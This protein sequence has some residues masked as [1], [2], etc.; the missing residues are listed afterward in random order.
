MGSE[1]QWPNP[2]VGP[3]GDCVA[4]R[5]FEVIAHLLPPRRANLATKPEPMESATLAN[6]GPTP[7][8]LAFHVNKIPISAAIEG[9]GAQDMVTLVLRRNRPESR[10]APLYP[11]KQ[12]VD[13]LTS[14]KSGTT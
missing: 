14:T 7:L 13:M 3:V 8:K 11:R 2:L 12:E 6:T 4:S 9:R 10:I 1:S 5:H